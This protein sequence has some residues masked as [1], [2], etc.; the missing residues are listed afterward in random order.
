[1][2]PICHILSIRISNRVSATLNARNTVLILLTTA[3]AMAVSCGS[4]DQG[5]PTNSSLMFVPRATGMWEMSANG[6][7]TT[8]VWGQ[9]KSEL[10]PFPNPVDSIMTMRF[11][12]PFDSTNVAVWAVKALGPFDNEDNFK[13]VG[14]AGVFVFGGDKTLLIFEGSLPKDT[15]S[16]VSWTTDSLQSGFY[17]IYLAIAGKIQLA[18]I[19]VAHDSSEVPFYI[20]KA[21]SRDD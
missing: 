15:L 19:F 21:F 6:I 11:E 10:V 3:F 12:T 18:D 8:G 4:L 16:S 2:E 20:Q 9:P 1:M 13:S 5:S 17:T 7:D 14:G